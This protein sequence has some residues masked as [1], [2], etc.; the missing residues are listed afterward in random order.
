MQEG[1]VSLIRTDQTETV[2]GSLLENQQKPWRSQAGRARTGTDVHTG[3]AGTQDQ[4]S[5]VAGH[6]MGIWGHSRKWLCLA[7]GRPGQTVPGGQRKSWQYGD[8][9]ASVRESVQLAGA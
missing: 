5:H 3:R 7:G 9:E 4:K 2:A 8:R 1:Q 6:R